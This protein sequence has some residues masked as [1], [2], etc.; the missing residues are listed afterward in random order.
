MLRIHILLVYLMLS[1]TV[2]LAQASKTKVIRNKFEQGELKNDVPTGDWRYF[3]EK[4]QPDLFINYE[5]GRITYS[6]PDSAYHTLRIKDQW[7]VV[8][9]ARSPRLVGSRDKYM[10]TAVKNFRYPTFALRMQTQGSVT[11]SFTVTHAG[12]VADVQVDGSPGPELTKEVLRVM[13]MQADAW[14]PAVYEGKPHDARVSIVTNF[15]MEGY[16]GRPIQPNG[17]LSL[18][19]TTTVKSQSSKACSRTA[20]RFAEFTL[21]NVR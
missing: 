15:L 16:N 7:Q 8:M 10:A 5:S 18:V 21:T 4:G 19:G 1:A 11:I 12:E 2:G 14:L 6:K 20:G 3:D 17:D 9:P 13:G